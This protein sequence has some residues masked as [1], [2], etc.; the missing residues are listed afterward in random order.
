MAKKKTIKAKKTTKKQAKKPAKKSTAR[1]RLLLA[2]D[3]AVESTND[4]RSRAVKTIAGRLA[5]RLGTGIDV[6]HVEDSTYY[7]VRDPSFARLF[8]Q[9]AREQKTRL[10]DQGV[11]PEQVDTRSLLVSG[12]PA[13]KILELAGK[14]PPAH[15]LV[16]VGT[17]ARRGL[18]RLLVGSVAEEVVRNS[19]LPVM[20]VGPE[21]QENFDK[22][23]TGEKMRILVPTGLTKNSERAENY[24]LALAK[25]LGAEVVLF[26]SL[27][28]VLHPVIQSFFGYPAIP[29]DA[30]EL[31]NE[32]KRNA[33]SAL[34]KKAEAFRKKGVSASAVLDH[35]YQSSDTAV[36]LEA[37]KSQASL[38]VMGTHGRSLLGGAF[39]GR[40]ARGVLLGAKVPVITVRSRSQ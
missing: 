25:R 26:H 15:E 32:L 20:T 12:S 29:A 18:N 30:A 8:E 5:L 2:D 22:I 1:P 37:E 34:T 3:I 11:V 9:F 6:L 13:A 17:Q 27:Y 16:V 14:R 10:E 36:T 23:F 4:R 33:L 21:V 24:A 28:D 19:P 35:Q 31:L 38:I 40:T 7:P 39:L